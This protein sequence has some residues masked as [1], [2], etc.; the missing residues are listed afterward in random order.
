MT[1]QQ[2]ASGNYDGAPEY[3]ALRRWAT[4]EDV[5]LRWENGLWCATLDGC[6]GMD[7]T[8]SGALYLL[9]NVRRS[10]RP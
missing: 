7:S 9:H 1:H 8:R 4:N 5:K 2:I 6:G 10:S 3:A